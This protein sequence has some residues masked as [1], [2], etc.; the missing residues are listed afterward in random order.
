MEDS[1][2]DRSPVA[3]CRRLRASAHGMFGQGENYNNDIHDPFQAFDMPGYGGSS[4]DMLSLRFQG[5]KIGSRRGTRLRQVRPC[6]LSS[7]RQGL[8]VEDSTWAEPSD[9]IL[10][11]REE[12]LMSESRMGYS[13]GDR[14]YKLKLLVH[15]RHF[16]PIMSCY[17][18]S[19]CKRV[20]GIV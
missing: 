18:C 12:Y 7:K 17:F 3:P 4:A 15:L 6:I 19:Q 1:S 14:V 5:K 13:D 16:S 10:D 20:G 2:A 9:A 8:L 11:P